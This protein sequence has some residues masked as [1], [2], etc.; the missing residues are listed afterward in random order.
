MESVIETAPAVGP[1]RGG[2]SD[3]T[4]GLVD[5]SSAAYWEQGYQRGT[6][7]ADWYVD[8]GDYRF[9]IHGLQPRT[10]QPGT[11]RRRWHA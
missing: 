4:V 11:A 1:A 5:F 10:L 6:A 8:Y 9:V 2:A 7:P 3:A